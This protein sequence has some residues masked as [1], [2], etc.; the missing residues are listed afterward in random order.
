MSHSFLTPY[1]LPEVIKKTKLKSSKRIGNN[2]LKQIS[3][4]IALVNLSQPVKFTIQVMNATI[5]SKL[6]NM[7]FFPLVG[8]QLASGMMKF[9]IK[10][11]SY[12][13]IDD[14]IKTIV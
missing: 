8:P 9:G 2:F 7:S 10:L 6:G 3:Y 5:I 11:R 4:C 1:F 13:G 12:Q 14:Q